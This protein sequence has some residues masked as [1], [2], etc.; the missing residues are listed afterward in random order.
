MPVCGFAVMDSCSVYQDPPRVKIKMKSANRGGPHWLDSFGADLRW[1][2]PLIMPPV[3]SGGL[4]FVMDTGQ[5]KVNIYH[6]VRIF[7]P[8]SNIFTKVFQGVSR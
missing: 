5:N 1:K 7:F 8:S 2:P 4:T 6:V 3:E